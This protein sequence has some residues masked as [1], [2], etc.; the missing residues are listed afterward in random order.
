MYKKTIDKLTKV[1]Y[2]KM[3]GEMNMSKIGNSVISMLERGYTMEEITNGQ[4]ELG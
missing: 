3:E 1:C 4:V 2:T